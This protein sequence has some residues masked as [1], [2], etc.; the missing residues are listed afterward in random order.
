MYD[1]ASGFTDMNSYVVYD[2]E[3]PFCTQYV[4]LVRLREAIGPVKPVNAREDHAVVRYLK[5]KG[6]DLNQEMALVM[7]GEI[8]T[9]P[10]CMHRLALLSTGSG[11]FNGLMSRMFASRGLT[12]TL[13]PFLRAG[14][15]LTLR[16]LGRKQIA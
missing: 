14:R 4:K 2:G 3:C 16:A 9:G 10:D 15:N 5:S 11:F 7:K 12:R 13:Y 1:S 6:V 8:F